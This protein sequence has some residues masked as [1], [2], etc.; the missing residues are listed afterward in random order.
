MKKLCALISFFSVIQITAHEEFTAITTRLHHMCAPLI[1]QAH[2]IEKKLE[3]SQEQYNANVEKTIQHYL[4]TAEKLPKDK[5]V[6]VVTAYKN[7]HNILDLNHV[8]TILYSEKWAKIL[9]KLLQQIAQEEILQITLLS[10]AVEA[11][12]KKQTFVDY[13]YEQLQKSQQALEKAGPEQVQQAFTLIQQGQAD[14]EAFV[15]R[16][17]LDILNPSA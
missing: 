4:Q 5:Q 1:Y 3:L 16:V 10:Q 2:A 11:L 9:I 17:I 13:S 6:A 12:N 7:M 15:N 8:L 14:H